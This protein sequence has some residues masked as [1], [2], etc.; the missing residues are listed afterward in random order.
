MTE[1]DFFN[2]YLVDEEIEWRNL[3]CEKMSSVQMANFHFSWM[4]ARSDQQM[5][6]EVQGESDG[7]REP[8]K[9]RSLKLPAYK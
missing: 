4:D 8:L 1:F 9:V 5:E 6:T 7:E 3:Q 2:F